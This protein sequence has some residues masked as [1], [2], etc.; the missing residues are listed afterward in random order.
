MQKC[1]HLSESGQSRIGDG[2]W[3]SAGADALR[4]LAL[5]LR[6][7][8]LRPRPRGS[9]RRCSTGSPLRPAASPAPVRALSGC[10]VTLETTAVAPPTPHR[11]YLGEDQEARRDHRRREGHDVPRPHRRLVQVRSVGRGSPRGAPAPLNLSEWRRALRSSPRIPSSSA[12]AS[13]TRTRRPSLLPARRASC[14]PAGG[15]R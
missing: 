15:P 1:Q 4:Y 3:A 10:E 13:R 11:R 9:R 5:G 8:T 7:T 6:T 12:A 2:R 14:S